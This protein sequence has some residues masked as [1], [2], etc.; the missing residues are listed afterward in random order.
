MARVILFGEP[1]G[2]IARALTRI[3]ARF[4]ARSEPAVVLGAVVAGQPDTLIWP[5]R[6]DVSDAR[7][8]RAIRD[9]APELRILLFGPVGTAAVHELVAELDGVYVGELPVDPQ[10]LEDTLDLVLRDAADGPASA[11]G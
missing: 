10:P 9:L 2:R 4:E 8:L 1:E 5:L 6:G 3:G 7:V 11:T